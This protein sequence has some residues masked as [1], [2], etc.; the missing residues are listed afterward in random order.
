[1]RLAVAVSVLAVMFAARAAVAETRLA[2]NV[3]GGLEGGLITG[4]ARP[5]AVAE[6]GVSA[7][8]LL[9]GREWGFGVA[10]ERVSRLT[11]RFEIAQELELDAMFRFKRKK[12]RVGVGAGMRTMT[13]EPTETWQRATVRGIDLIRFGWD[14][15]ATGWDVGGS[16]VGIHLYCTWTFGGYFGEVRGTRFGDM[17]TPVKSISFGESLTTTY[18][19]GLLTSVSW[20]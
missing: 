8:W 12:F 17:A 7:D 11:T 14:T 18:V 15:E 13:I 9:P 5:D 10:V 2:A 6:V 16:R 3:G 1:M 19:L 4:A 20:P